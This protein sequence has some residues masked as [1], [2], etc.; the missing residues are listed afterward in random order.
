M[1]KKTKG[2][3]INAIMI[4]LNNIIKRKN[5]ELTKHNLYLDQK[6]LHGSDMFFKLAFMSDS[7]I[8]KIATSCGL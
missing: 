2:I 8:K 6:P 1:T 4:T 3:L 5:K 7:D